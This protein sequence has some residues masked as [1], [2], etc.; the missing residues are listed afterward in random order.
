[1]HPK[2]L[3]VIAS[4][5]LLACLACSGLFAQTPAGDSPFTVE[6]NL[7]DATKPETVGLAQA[8]G[9]QTVTVFSSTEATDHYCNGVA[10]VSFK[11]RLY[12]QWQSSKTDEDSPDSWVAYSSSADGLNWDAPKVLAK[13]TEAFAYTSGGWWTDGTTLVAYVNVWPG[14]TPRGGFTKYITSGDGITWAPL[15]SLKDSAGNDLAGIFEQ[16]PHALPS[17]RIINEVHAQ[18]GLI[19]WPYFTD[20]PKGI[21]GWTRAEMPHMVSK[22]ADISAELEPSWYLRSDGAAVMVFRDQNGSYKKLA[23]L[24]LDQGKTWT[25]PV[26]TEMPDSRCKQSAGNLPNGTAYQV[27]VPSGSKVRFPLAVTLSRD[28]KVFDRAFLLRSGNSSD[29]P[30]QRY[31]GKAKTLGYSY[32]KSVV[33]G[34]YLY[35]GYSTNKEDIQITRIPLKSLAY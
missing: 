34:D 14:L 5:A 11:G 18:P 12:I 22:S 3:A 21:S 28:G 13:N 16:D 7:F 20:D 27:S 25:L 30:T 31:T 9:T 15:Q 24:S 4:A 10:L 2:K 1:M 33:W 19:L 23:S 35:V 6:P 8:A 17:G 26:V 29:L 32:P